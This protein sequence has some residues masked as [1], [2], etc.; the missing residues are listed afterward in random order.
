MFHFNLSMQRLVTLL[1]A[2]VPEFQNIDTSRVLLSASFTRTSRRSGLIAYVLPLKFR[3]GS[4]VEMKLRG[5]RN[6]H[7][8][9]LP[10][11]HE[12]QEI[13]Y[14]IYFLLPRFQNLKP[15]EKLETVVHE[16]YHISPLFNGDL[17]RL[18]GRSSVH[19]NSLKEYDAVIRAITDRFL[20]K[21]PPLEEFEFLKC[22]Y[23]QAEKRWGNV[24][25]SHIREPRPKLLKVH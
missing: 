23:R 20:E 8:A 1:V 16:L 7:Y 12:G 11:Y 19:G 10:Y 14:I 25:A 17:R 6:Y 18:K 2:N 21:N 22:N 9:M 5:G 3:E 4:P 15:R 13:L 24:I